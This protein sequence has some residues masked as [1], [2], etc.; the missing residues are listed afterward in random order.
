MS[1]VKRTISCGH[2]R[3]EHTGEQITLN[4]WA[5]KIRDLGGLLFV[6]LRD[7]TGL[8]QLVL[9][10]AGFPNRGELRPETCLAVTGNV[11]MRDE[12]V[13]NPKLGTGDIEVAVTAYSILGPSK[14]LPF[15]VSDEEQMSTVNEELRV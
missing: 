7:R 6:D 2:V 8:V 9:D 13:R 1:F 4:G 14:T 3:S 5:H 15:P 10:P 12:A 11:R